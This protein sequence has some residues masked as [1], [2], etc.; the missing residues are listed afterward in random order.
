MAGEWMLNQMSSRGGKPNEY[1]DLVYGKVVS[2]SPLK[3][4]LSNSMILTDNFLTLGL[5]VTKHKV[6][7]TYKDRTDTSDNDRTEEVEVDE[8]LK[9]GDGVVMIRSDGG[10]SFFVLE[11]TGGDE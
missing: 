10:Q 11:K 7:I 3:I 5:H 6:K 2:V 1:A 8:S 4:Q 9:A